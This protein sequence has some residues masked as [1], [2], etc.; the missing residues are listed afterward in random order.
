M[1]INLYHS[2]AY[3]QKDI[4]VT[5]RTV[6]MIWRAA[7]CFRSDLPKAANAEAIDPSVTD[8]FSQ[9][10]KVRSFAKKV[11]GSTRDTFPGGS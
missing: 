7:A 1:E 3:R 9:E 6:A 2:L 5:T 11:L 10:R 8:M 4:A